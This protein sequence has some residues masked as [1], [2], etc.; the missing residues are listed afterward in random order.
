MTNLR[1]LEKHLNE[2]SHAYALD[3][4][5][6]FS[7]ITVRRF[8]LPP[9]FNKGYVGVLLRLVDYPSIAPGIRP[10]AVYLP[11]GLQLRGMK[12]TDYHEGTGP[13]GWAWW[14]FQ[15]IDW[16]PCSDDLITFL[17][18]LR[19]TLTDRPVESPG[20]KSWIGRLFSG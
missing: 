2:L 4:S 10:S 6:D 16:N 3:V 11:E 12:P 9:G 5:K 7:W 8:M 15:R 17:E 13:T 14:C 20:G 1:L 19:A 18:M